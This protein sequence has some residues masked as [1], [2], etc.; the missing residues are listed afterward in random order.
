M[1]EQPSS[2]V[3]RIL[4][5]LQPEPPGMSDVPIPEWDPA[6]TA[7]QREELVQLAA[8]ANNNLETVASESATRGFN[9]GCFAGLFPGALMMILMFFVTGWS[10]IGAAFG[11]L[12]TL[13]SM[14]AF[15]SLAAAVTRR[16]TVR[17]TYQEIVLPLV[18]QR[19]YQIELKMPH[20]EQAAYQS[21]PAAAPLL[22][23]LTPTLTT[24]PE[25]HP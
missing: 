21:L 23:Y 15:A 3:S 11:L 6:L 5:R 4:D 24:T 8:D 16:N 10:L 12:L 19:L 1:S 13:I 25:M 22:A 2:I 17:R 9:L 7:E 20:F 14:A 18:K